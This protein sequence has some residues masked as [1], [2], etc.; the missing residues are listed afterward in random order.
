[1]MM[2]QVLRIIAHEMGLQV[3]AEAGSGDGVMA[4]INERLPDI[5]L[6]DINLPGEDGLH[7]LQR[8]QEEHPDIKVVMISGDTAQDKVKEAIEHGAV[9]FIA[10]PFNPDAVM[11]KLKRLIPELQSNPA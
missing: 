10:K 1:M 9:D 2:R 3:A 5:M 7:I 11:K 4:I 8:V 6:L